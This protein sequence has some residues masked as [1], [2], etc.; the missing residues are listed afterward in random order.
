MTIEGY[1]CRR[2]TKSCNRANKNSS[3][4]NERSLFDISRIT[5]INCLAMSIAIFD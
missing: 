5:I 3:F 4:L 1:Y 2:L